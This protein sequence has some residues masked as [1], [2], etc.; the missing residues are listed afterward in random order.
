MKITTVVGGL[1]AIIALSLILTFTGQ[2]EAAW[3]V[4]NIGTLGW[5]C[6]CLFWVMPPPGRPRS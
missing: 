1:L 4:S 3:V 6:W 2:A 5:L